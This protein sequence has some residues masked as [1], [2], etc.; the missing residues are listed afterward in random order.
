MFF[1]SRPLRHTFAATLLFAFAFTEIPARGAEKS[2]FH[3]DDYQIEAILTPHEHK[4]TARAKVKITAIEDL[5]IATFQL[6]S[7][8]RLSKVTDAAGK[9]LTADRNPQDS[10]VRVSLNTALP[11]DQSTTLT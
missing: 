5:N 4:L 6:H 3:V 7:L 9:A 2:H 1:A 10:S 8:L 11:K